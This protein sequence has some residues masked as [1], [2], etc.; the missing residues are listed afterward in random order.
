VSAR[1]DL[2]GVRIR[3][4]HMIIYDNCLPKQCLLPLVIKRKTSPKED[5]GLIAHSLGMQEMYFNNR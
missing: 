2:H 1:K 4:N 5:I 3:D